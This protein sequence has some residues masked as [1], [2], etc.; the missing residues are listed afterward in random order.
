MRELPAGSNPH[1][2]IPS[3]KCCSC[4]GVDP[5]H[6][7]H[8]GIPAT[9]PQLPKEFGVFKRS[10][11]K[12]SP[13][14]LPPPPPPRPPSRGHQRRPSIQTILSSNHLWFLRLAVCFS[15]SPR[16]QSRFISPPCWRPIHF[17][18]RL[19]RAHPRSIPNIPFGRCARCNQPLVR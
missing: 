12:S 10:A 1:P 11:L 9:N 4:L 3:P 19:R 2:S 8:R 16:G 6:D 14:I 13:P 7:R 5:H 15:K 18:W 17:S